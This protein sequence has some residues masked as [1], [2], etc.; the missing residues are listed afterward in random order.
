VRRGLP[1][2]FVKGGCDSP[3]RVEWDDVTVRG[4]LTRG[5]LV[6]STF[7]RR[8]YCWDRP[9]R[10]K[11]DAIVEDLAKV[12]FHEWREHQ[13]ADETRRC[14]RVMWMNKSGELSFERQGAGQAVTVTLEPGVR[15]AGVNGQGSYWVQRHGVHFTV[16]LCRSNLLRMVAGRS[17]RSQSRNCIWRCLRTQ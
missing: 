9:T 7:H 6:L 12:L 14:Q 10:E 8:G 4:Y 15:L 11:G 16:T 1:V 13:D 17:V 5:E 3:C 2:A